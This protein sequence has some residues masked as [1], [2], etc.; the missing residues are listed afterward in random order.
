V[1]CWWSLADY[2]YYVVCDS[3]L[4]PPQSVVQEHVRT[5]AFLR[6]QARQ[7]LPPADSNSDSSDGEIYSSDDGAPTIRIFDSGVKRRL[8]ESIE[9]HTKCL[10]DLLPSMEQIY[11]NLCDLGVRLEESKGKISFHA[12][13][14]ARPYVLQ[15]H[16]KFKNASI[17]LVERLGEANWQRFLRLRQRMTA[18]HHE[19]VIN[20]LQV[21]TRSAFS[22]FNSHD[23][24]L[25][26]SLHP[27]SSFTQTDALHSSCVSS[28]AE[29]GDSCARV[30]P[31]PRGVVDGT[32]FQCFI[33][34]RMLTKIRNRIDW[35]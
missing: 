19:D 13:D 4:K 33:C 12:T 25:G 8:L 16:N 14:A 6:E 23:S 28:L 15:V 31:T 21:G 7:L 35:K 24:G 3:S 18:A 9:F 22:T 5:L 32:P 2:D 27:D 20:D 10:M 11:K 26:S 29:K 17:S 30:P 1:F 34:G